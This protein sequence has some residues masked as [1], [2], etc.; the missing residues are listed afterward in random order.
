MKAWVSGRF[1]PAGAVLLEQEGHGVEPEPVQAQVE[2]VPHH[3]EHGVGHFGVVVVEVGLVGVEAVPVVLVPLGVVGPVGPLHVDEHHPGLGPPLVVVVP[4]VPVGLGVVSALAGL[5]EP[6]V[7]VAG[8]VDDQVGDD[9]DAPG[10]GLLEQPPQ[11]VDGA[12]LG[13]D[14]V[15]VAD[16][17]AAVP[18]RRGVEGQQPE[19]V[20]AEPLEVVQ[21]GD[22]AGDV[23]HPVVVAV[24]EA[25][26]EHLVEDGPLEPERILLGRGQ[27][28]VVGDR[29]GQP[30]ERGERN[31]QYGGSRAKI[32]RSR[33]HA[34]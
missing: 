31:R 2:P 29:M 12:R 25:A 14:R 22:E 19:A 11:V 24:E 23:A 17:V 1:S 16:V 15:V 26:D 10:V 20:D 34:T 8:V 5:D 33:W 27:R 6:G 9:P 30:T 32:Q 3:V 4:H 21:L 28:G 18:E 13:V 7:L